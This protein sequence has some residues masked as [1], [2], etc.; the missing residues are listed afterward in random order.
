MPA[1]KM[2]FQVVPPPPPTGTHVNGPPTQKQE[3]S[4]PP[5]V[6]TA[7]SE[8]SIMTPGH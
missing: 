2:M 8:A 4:L 3:S 7:Y 6:R 5:T 1:Q